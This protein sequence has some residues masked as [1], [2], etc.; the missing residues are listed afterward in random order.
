MEQYGKSK[1]NVPSLTS[2]Q[3]SQNLLQQT[4]RTGGSPEQAE[5]K[6][7]KS[8]F[9]GKAAAGAAAPHLAGA[10]APQVDAG[11]QP[12]AE[13][14]QR[15]PVHQVEVEVV[16]ELWSVQNFERNFGYFARGFPRR[17]QKFLTVEQYTEKLKCHIA[18]QRRQHMRS[19]Y[20]LLLLTGEREYG[21]TVFPSS[22]D[23][24]LLVLTEYC[25]TN[26]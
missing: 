21:E 25:K 16:L 18:Q 10:G 8:E 23:R 1:K 13:H 9:T 7:A 12:H 4:D 19:F 22:S 2:P 14:V 3:T 15:R 24:A 20:Y 17:P 26:R 11:A 5:G 6:S